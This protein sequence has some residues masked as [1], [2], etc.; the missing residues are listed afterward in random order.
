MPDGLTVTE[1]SEALER[2]RGLR[3]AIE[4]GDLTLEAAQAKVDALI[5]F[6]EKCLRSRGI[7]NP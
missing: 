5:E 7:E 6:V 4:K 2:L 1:F 3:E